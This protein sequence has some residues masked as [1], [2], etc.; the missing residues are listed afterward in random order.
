MVT[1]TSPVCYDD[2]C[3]L[4]SLNSFDAFS[5]CTEH[6]FLSIKNI[7]FYYESNYVY[8]GADWCTVIWMVAWSAVKLEVPDLK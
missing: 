3:R 6:T 1:P 5:Q 2:F 8:Y 7:T 4:E